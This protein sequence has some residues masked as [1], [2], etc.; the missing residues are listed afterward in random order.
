MA[1]NLTVKQ[2]LN[3]L[4]NAGKRTSRQKD[5]IKS[6]TGEKRPTKKRRKPITVGTAR[7]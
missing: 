3:L 1:K 2:A 5:F 6:I 7:G 4:K